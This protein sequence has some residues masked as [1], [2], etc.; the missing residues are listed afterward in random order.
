MSHTIDTV[1]E[2]AM[3]L[4]DDDRV[5]LADRLFFTLSPQ[6]QAEI[7]AAWAVEAERRMQEFRD[8]KVKGVPWEEVRDSL[9]NRVKK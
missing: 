2:A 1:F 3:T 9:L 8:G 7:D 5:E 4:S 6:R